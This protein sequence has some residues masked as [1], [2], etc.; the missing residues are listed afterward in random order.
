MYSNLANILFET[1]IDS[2]K[3]SKMINS[4]EQNKSSHSGPP[5]IIDDNF[6]YNVAND[7]IS[8][9][10]LGLQDSNYA[11]FLIDYHKNTDFKKTLQTLLSDI[12]CIYLTNRSLD[13]ITRFTITIKNKLLKKTIYQKNIIV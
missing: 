11:K 4:S 1:Q 5:L 10:D 2:M 7:E 9:S 13:T 3:K 8:A 12:F 6:G